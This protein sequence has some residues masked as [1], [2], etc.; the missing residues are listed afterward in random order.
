MLRSNACIFSILFMDKFYVI[1]LVSEHGN[2]ILSLL[3]SVIF[4]RFFLPFS[5]SDIK[6]NMKCTVLNTILLLALYHD[7][8]LSKQSTVRLL[9]MMRQNAGDRLNQTWHQTVSPWI[10]K[11]T[12]SVA[13]Q[14]CS[15]IDLAYQLDKSARNLVKDSQEASPL[16]Q[17][18]FKFALQKKWTLHMAFRVRY[19]LAQL[20]LCL[21]LA[22]SS[23]RY[24]PRPS[25][26]LGPR[27]LRQ[28]YAEYTYSTF[29]TSGSLPPPVSSSAA[30]STSLGYV[31]P[32]HF[33]QLMLSL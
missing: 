8:N 19:Q 2:Y 24:Q 30:P 12:S 21:E 6:T 13:S 31:L 25:H 5:I 26:C 15:N 9:E 32:R 27:S 33:P 29:Y 4:M 23:S 20:D 14:K 11:T 1:I 28:I 18:T 10:F 7:L 16:P 17:I 22:P 3:L